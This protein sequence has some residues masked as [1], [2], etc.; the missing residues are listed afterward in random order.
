VLTWPRQQQHANNHGYRRRDESE[1]EQE[2][3][4]AFDHDSLHEMGCDGLSRNTRS[5]MSLA[6]SD[7][8]LS[9]FQW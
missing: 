4:S 1:R 8:K 6:T 7:P 2:F 5:T 9:D 3:E